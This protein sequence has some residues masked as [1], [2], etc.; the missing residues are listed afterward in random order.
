VKFTAGLQLNRNHSNQIIWQ[1]G[2]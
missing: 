1:S 2:F